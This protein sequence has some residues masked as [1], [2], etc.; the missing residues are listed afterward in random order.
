MF[1]YLYSVPDNRD[2][3]IECSYF[4]LMNAQELK[5]Y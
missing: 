1:I 2:H 5:K 3:C 4:R